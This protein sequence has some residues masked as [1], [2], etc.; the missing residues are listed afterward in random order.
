MK[1]RR[2]K[3]KGLRRLSENG[4]TAGL[5]AQFVDKIRNI[6]AF[7]QD[8]ESV[9]ELRA[10]PSWKAHLM[11]GDRKGTWSLFVSK[12][13]RITFRINETEIEIIEL[14]YEDYH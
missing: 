1:I 12:N 4:N 7:L 6:L 14:D 10:I 2:V 9:E 8:M 13:W 5:P 3:H 11:T